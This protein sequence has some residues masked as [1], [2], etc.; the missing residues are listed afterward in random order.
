MI[1][2]SST[3]NHVYIVESRPYWHRFVTN[4]VTKNDIV[5]TFDFGVK[6]ELER[7]DVEVHYVDSLCSPWEMLENNFLAS[8][9]I[10]K[11]HYD[12]SDK[13]I[14][15]EQDVSFGFAFRIEIW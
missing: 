3:Y 7:L 13:D 1:D 15:N 12:K 5:L 2:F 11:W 9:F 10:K 14:F 6:F 4:T 8:D